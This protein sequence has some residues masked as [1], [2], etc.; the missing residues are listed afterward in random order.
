MP[1]SPTDIP[2]F[3]FTHHRIGLHK[4]VGENTANESS[5]VGSL[6]LLDE[7]SHLLE[8]DR[9]RGLGLAYLELSDKQGSPT[10]FETY[11]L[12]AFRLLESV[13]HDGMRDGD[14]DAALAR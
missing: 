4:P 13:R 14:V 12:R 9:V 3:A 5:G 11:R 2:H 8:I 7:M 1:Q 10:A 6:V